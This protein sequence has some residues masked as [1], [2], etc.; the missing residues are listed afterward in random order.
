[1]ELD[2]MKV[3]WRE[4]NHRLEQQQSISLKQMR[5]VQL[6]N[7]RHGLRP[8]FWGQVLQMI[9]GVFV[10]LFAASYWTNHRDVPHQLVTGLIVHIYGVLMICLGGIMIAHIGKIDYAAPVATI[11]KKLAQLR[12]LYIRCG[13]MIGLPWWVLWI[14]FMMVVFGLLGADLYANAP[15]VIS[16]GTAIGMV[17]LLATWA[18]HHWSHHP[19]RPGLAQWLDD[20]VAGGSL[21]KARKI[22][23]E[24][25]RFEQ[26]LNEGQRPQ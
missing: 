16:I 10:I 9:F 18:F 26:E 7:A 6:T 20:S 3:A 23:D 12:C 2:E 13:M 19:S 14:P 4:L 8:L 15:E 11:Q 22:L 1:M 5:D 21:T 25:V 17:G 24:I